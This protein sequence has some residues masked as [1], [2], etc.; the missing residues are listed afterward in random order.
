MK[1]S[2]YK[3][4]KMGKMGK[5]EITIAIPSYGN[6]TTLKRAIDS[7]CGLKE[8]EGISWK[9]LISE[10]SSEKHKDIELLVKSCENNKIKYVFH[11]PRLG[12]VDN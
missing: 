11:N 1:K 8:I 3:K 2:F 6:I 12:M 4:T 7:V 9:L 5:Y 10:D